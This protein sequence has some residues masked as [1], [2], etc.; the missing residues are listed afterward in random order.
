MVAEKQDVKFVS[1]VRV[2]RQI[3]VI[4][5]QRYVRDKL[6]RYAVTK[7]QVKFYMVR[8]ATEKITETV[9]VISIHNRVRMVIL[10]VVAAEDI[11]LGRVIPY[12]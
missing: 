12:V 8:N 9:T 2:G 1:R 3:A 5:L 11:V 10:L 6:Q 7:K 4:L